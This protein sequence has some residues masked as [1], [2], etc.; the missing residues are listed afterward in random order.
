MIILV[1]KDILAHSSSGLGRRPLKAE[2]TGSNP[3]CATILS[4]TFVSV[5]LRSGSGRFAFWGNLSTFPRRVILSSGEPLPRRVKWSEG[6][7]LRVRFCPQV[8]QREQQLLRK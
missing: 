8:P 1:R 3:V 7:R 5:R 2:I 4:N 6:E